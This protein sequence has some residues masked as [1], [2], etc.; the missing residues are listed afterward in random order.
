MK[1]LP[2]LLLFLSFANL[3]TVAQSQ[4]PGQQK[5]P[6]KI[7]V[8]AGAYDPPPVRFNDL[9]KLILDRK[10]KTIV[11]EPYAPNILRVTLSLERENAL[12]KPGYGFVGSP[13]AAG[14]TKNQTVSC[15]ILADGQ[16]IVPKVRSDIEEYG[17]LRH[18][19]YFNGS[20]P[21]AHITFTTPDG[22]KLL[23]MTGWDQAVPNHKDGSADLKNDRRPTDPPFFTVGATFVSPDDEHYYGLGDN[24]EGLR[25]RAECRS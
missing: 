17:A 11:L 3:S 15:Q 24:Q 23:E 19:K 6:E 8:K 12:E 16:G 5:T 20:T 9:N 4:D 7:L 1:R 25:R 2:V 14:W 13:N 10:G 18:R 21:G 22:K